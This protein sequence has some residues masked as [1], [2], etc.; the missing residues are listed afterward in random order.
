[1]KLIMRA[2][3]IQV[4]CVRHATKEVYTKED[5]KHIILLIRQDL[6]NSGDFGT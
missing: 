6:I 1:M 3:T 2:D 4:T 5:Y